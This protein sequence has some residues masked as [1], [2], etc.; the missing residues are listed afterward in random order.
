MH[1]ISPE[2]ALSIVKSNDRVFIH[3]GSA[4]PSRLVDAL[5]NRHVELSN[6][7]I[8]HL[9][10]EGGAPYADPAFASS[11]HVNAFFVGKNV[12]KHVN[13]INVQYIPMFLSDIPLFIRKKKFPINVA[14]IQVCPPDEHGFCSLGISVDI[15][16]AACEVA[17]K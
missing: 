7:E 17:E 6:V 15:T 9:H 13:E 2:E 12:R 11:F 3:G 4:T 16:K 14:I 5:T 1:F 8:A 10:T